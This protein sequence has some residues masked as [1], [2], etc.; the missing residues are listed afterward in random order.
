MGTV[1]T[2]WL[3]ASGQL[4]AGLF[5][6]IGPFWSMRELPDAHEDHA[7]GRPAATDADARRGGAEPGR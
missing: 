4:L 7:N 2:L 6:V 5:V 3:A 1:P